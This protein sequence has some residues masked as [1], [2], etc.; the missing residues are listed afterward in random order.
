M[1]AD[2]ELAPT[3]I[4]ELA[5]LVVERLAT[6]GRTRLTKLLYLIDEGHFV[7]YGATLTGGAWV[8][9]TYGPMLAE[10]PG[11]GR[12]LNAHELVIKPYTDPA[13]YEHVDYM[14]AGRA[15]WR[16][17]PRFRPHEVEVIED[18]LSRF[19]EL[20][21]AELIRLAYA[22]PPM[23]LIQQWEEGAERLDGTAVPFLKALGLPD[24]GLDRYRRIAAAVRAEP[25]GTPG[26][27]RAAEGEMLEWTSRLRR[28]ATHAAIE[29]LEGD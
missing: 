23:R 18:V 4:H 28:E 16:F 19:G 29:Q 9:Y 2:R 21:R 3:R 8:R 17:E 13:G 6:V 5:A 20:S 27:R 7:R 1:R 12:D 14:A 25:E 11:V 26:E 22:T 10:L 24:S 15:T